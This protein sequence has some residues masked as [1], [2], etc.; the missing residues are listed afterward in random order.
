[1]RWLLPD[2]PNLA[3]IL[4]TA[5]SLLGPSCSRYNW[6]YST[7]VSSASEIPQ[8]A[9]NID[10]LLSF[11]GCLHSPSLD[12]SSPA[13]KIQKCWFSSS[14]WPYNSNT[15]TYAY[16]NIKVMQH[17]MKCHTIITPFLWCLQSNVVI[18]HYSVTFGFSLRLHVDS[19]CKFGMLLD[20]CCW[21]LFPLLLA[22]F[23]CFSYISA[24]L[25][26]PSSSAKTFPRT[27]HNC[28]YMGITSSLANVWCDYGQ[29][30]GSS[31][32]G[33]QR[34]KSSSTAWDTPPAI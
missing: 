3:S 14:V 22:A 19:K 29:N 6:R 26:N 17:E 30:S 18:F 32:H 13:N 20:L 34:S 16:S 21:A 2:T 4:H 24:F 28:L 15:C 12:L 25:L 31:G 23:I 11:G 1:M 5:C 8:N 10:P 27:P 7:G 33:T 9:K